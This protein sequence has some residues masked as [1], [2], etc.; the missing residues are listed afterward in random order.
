MRS[1]PRKFGTEEELYAA[2]LRALMRRAHSIHEMR[3]YL[4]RR[5]DDPES[6]SNVVAKLRERTYLDDARY[7]LDYARS[8]AQSRR[9]GRFRIARELRSRGV[10]DR[11]IEAAV[12]AVFAETD[13]SSLVRARLKRRLSHVRGP[14]DQRKLASL[15]SSLLRAG[16]SSDIIRTE[17]RAATGG[18]A[19]ESTEVFPP[20][21]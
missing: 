18:S 5:S 15:Y 3:E 2:A 1:S 17:I 13:E 4:T 20:E 11:H 19:P 10:P 6:V 7:A 16:F 12:D 21:E 9:Q 8:H 14:L